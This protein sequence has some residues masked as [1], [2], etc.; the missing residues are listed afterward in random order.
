MKQIRGGKELLM[1]AKN[2]AKRK[3]NRRIKRRI[4]RQTKKLAGISGAPMVTSQ[5][6]PNLEAS[7]SK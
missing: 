5:E 4:K 7:T 6:I 1:K 3:D 2:E